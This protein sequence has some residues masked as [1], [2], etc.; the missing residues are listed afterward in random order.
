MQINTDDISGIGLVQRDPFKPL[1]TQGESWR[2]FLLANL[3]HFRSELRFMD[4]D[5]LWLQIG[6][7]DA[8]NR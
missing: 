5:E 8:L 2:F 1:P 3:G 6:V 4:N 7:K